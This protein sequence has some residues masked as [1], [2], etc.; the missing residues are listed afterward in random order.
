M[1]CQKLFSFRTYLTV[2]AVTVGLCAVGCGDDD[3]GGGD[4]ATD[5]AVTDTGTDTGTSDTGTTDTGTADSGAGD[6][7]PVNSCNVP[8]DC[9]WGEIDR[10]ILAPT[11]C[12]CLFGCPTL[13]LNTETVERRQA[14]YSE[15]CT[16]G[17]DG[18]GNPCP[19]DDCLPPPALRCVD[20]I[21]TASSDGG[22]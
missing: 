21:C 13:A 15:H 3:G 16:P 11:D 6:A 17:R 4:A 7:G 19:V 22:A 14:Q 1:D 8:E 12:I 10:E 9:A 5:T 18:E 2:A 20:N